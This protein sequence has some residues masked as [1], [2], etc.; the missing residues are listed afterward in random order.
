MNDIDSMI[1]AINS[2]TN[3]AEQCLKKCLDYTTISDIKSYESTY[4]EEQEQLKE[5][6][7]LKKLRT[8]LYRTIVAIPILA[9]VFVAQTTINLFLSILFVILVSVIWGIIAFYIMSG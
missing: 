3:L 9:I 6:K 5:Y 2:N 7:S 1:I 8:N 4:I